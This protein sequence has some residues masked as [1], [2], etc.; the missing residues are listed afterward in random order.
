[1]S[2]LYTFG[3]PDDITILCDLFIPLL[4]QIIVLNM[5][6]NAP[7]YDSRFAW[8]VSPR[9]HARTWL[10]IDPLECRDLLF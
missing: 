1:M 2:G 5:I 6:N 3:L 7:V 8:N 4:E 10:R 9:S